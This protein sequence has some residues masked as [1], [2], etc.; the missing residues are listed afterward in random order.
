MTSEGGR[1]DSRSASARTLVAGAPTS[2]WRLP[3][4]P[5]CGTTRITAVV[6]AVVAV[7]LAA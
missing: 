4:K 1:T 7:E 3:R 2:P 6:P 5:R